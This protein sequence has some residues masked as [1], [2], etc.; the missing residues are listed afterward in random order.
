MNYLGEI[1]SLGVAVSWTITALFAEVGSKRLGSL[2]LNVIR[3]VLSLVMLG[4]TLW[5][6]TGAPYP[7][8]AG[9][10]AW[11]W[12]SLSGFVGYLLGDYCLFN[13]Y[14]IIGS[15]FGQFKP[16]SDSFRHLFERLLN[17]LHE[18]LELLRCVSYGRP[19][20]FAVLAVKV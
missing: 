5:W 2:Q 4:A 1:I 11:L 6:F 12:L 13:S 7:L 20:K 9:G 3:M 10:K 15:R 18:L 16:L 19:Y 8:M 14:I 17:C